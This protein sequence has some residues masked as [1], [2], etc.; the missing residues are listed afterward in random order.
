MVSLPVYYRRAALC[1]RAVAAVAACVTKQY[2]K[3][4]FLPPC[5]P[6][7]KM[8]QSRA[9]RGDPVLCVAWTV[10]SSHNPE[11]Q[12]GLIPGTGSS[13][14]GPGGASGRMGGGGGV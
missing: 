8:G 7:A 1:E 4:R 11:L 3:A 9:K 12:L 13:L 6:V 5:V 10:L 2:G 14:R